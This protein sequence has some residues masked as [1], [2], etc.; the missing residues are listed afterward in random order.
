MAQ[1]SNSTSTLVNTIDINTVNNLKASMIVGAV[2]EASHINTLLNMY[3]TLLGHYHTYTDR[4]QEATFGAGYG[5]NPGA[6]DRTLY[7][8]SKSTGTP[9]AISGSITEVA[10]STI[11]NASKHNEIA[12]KSRQF[13]NHYHQID[14]RINL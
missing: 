7:E 3:N 11:I 9:Y 5:D 1:R 13:Q 12:L 14:D 4:I 2:I 8:E 6:G 10:A